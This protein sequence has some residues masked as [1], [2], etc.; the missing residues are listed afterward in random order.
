[1]ENSTLLLVFAPIL[2][3]VAALAGIFARGLGGKAPVQMVLG[4]IGERRRFEERAL[5]G[6]DAIN[7]RF[8]GLST[9]IEVIKSK[10]YRIES[11]VFNGKMEAGKAHRRAVAL[12]RAKR[13]KKR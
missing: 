11:F 9:D 1:M 12:R 5:E 4:E 8:A 10:V 7:G 2:G 3:L 6:I 13:S